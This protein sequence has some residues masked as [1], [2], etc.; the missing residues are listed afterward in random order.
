MQTLGQHLARQLRFLARSC[1]AFDAGHYDE[2][3]RIATVLRVMFHDTPRQVS[4]L[5]RLDAPPVHLLDTV[6]TPEDMA[7]LLLFNGVGTYL[8]GGDGRTKYMPTLGDVPFVRYLPFPK[9]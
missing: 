8:L 5:S 9:W 3:I 2:A 7:G 4:L 6:A 1:A